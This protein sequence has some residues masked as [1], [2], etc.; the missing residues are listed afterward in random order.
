M[1]NMVVFY[2]VELS[3]SEGGEEK[4]VSQTL[5]PTHNDK[6]CEVRGQDPRSEE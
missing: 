4:K 2:F 1:K 3:A 6:C 5:K